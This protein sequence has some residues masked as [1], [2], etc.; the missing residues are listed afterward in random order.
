ALVV[1]QAERLAREDPEDLAGV[2]LGVGEDDLLAPRL[3][4]AADA[5]GRP[6][7]AA[8]GSAGASSA[9]R[10]RASASISP[11]E[12]RRRTSSTRA[13]ASPRRMARITCFTD[14]MAAGFMLSSRTPSP[15]RMTAET[16][17]AAIS[18]QTDTL[19]PFRPAASTTR[20]IR[21]RIAGCRGWYRYA[22]DSLPR[23]IARV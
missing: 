3:R 7:R 21:S 2:A 13:R 12:S 17:W 10:A 11:G 22:T 15:A 5:H 16:G 23:S 14:G 1:L 8:A 6:P 19:T 4:H 20:R 18:P 9:T